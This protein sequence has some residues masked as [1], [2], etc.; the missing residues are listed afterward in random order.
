[1][2]VRGAW[3]SLE[4]QVQRERRESQDPSSPASAQSSLCAK[5]RVPLN[6]K[7]GRTRGLP[8]GWGSRGG[9]WATGPGR[10]RLRGQGQPLVQDIAVLPQLDTMA[11]PPRRTSAQLYT[12][13]QTFLVSP[14]RTP[15][16]RD[17]AGHRPRARGTRLLLRGLGHTRCQL[18]AGS[19]R[20]HAR[21]RKAHP[22]RPSAARLALEARACAKWRLG[23]CTCS[24]G[25]LPP[26]TALHLS[27][28]PPRSAESELALTRIP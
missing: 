14:N 25:P 10:T 22:N 23:V 11:P 16:G 6:Q 19:R 24:E 28:G 8:R 13:P 17:H 7:P 18:S 9:P 5:V 2:T 12:H 27:L 4:K 21:R 15:K 26:P 1:M 3:C 20:C